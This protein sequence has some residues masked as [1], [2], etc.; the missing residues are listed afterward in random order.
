MLGGRVAIDGPFRQCF[1]TDPFEFLVDTII[2]LPRGTN[3]DLL[4]PLERLSRTG[5]RERPG[6]VKSS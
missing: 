4:D 6:A 5:P 2:E 1:K 3:L